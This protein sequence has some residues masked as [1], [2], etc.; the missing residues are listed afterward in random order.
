MSGR[1]FLFM[2]WWIWALAVLLTSLGESF[3][4]EG[5]RRRLLERPADGWRTVW[6]A[7]QLGALSP[8]SRGRI[9][10]QAREL[11]ARRVSPLGVMA[12][13]VSAQS[14]L[15]WLLL[16]I[17]ELDGPQP[18]LGLAVAVAV[19]LAVLAFGLAR[20][21]AELWDAA[22]GDAAREFSPA[23]ERGS[24]P[25][26]RGGPVWL[27]LPMSALGQVYS[28]WWPMLV[29]LAGVGFFLAL[30]QSSGYFSLQGTRGPLIQVGNV[31]AGLLVAYVTGAPLVGHALIAAGL[32]KADF[33]TYAGLSAFYMGTMVTPFVIP[34]YYD[35]LGVALA[36]RVLVWLVAAI[37]VGA[38][39][40]TAWWWGLDWFAGVLGVRDWF[41]A[42]TASTLR[43]NNVPWFHHWF[44]P[45]L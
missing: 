21:P 45:G 26:G 1:H 4:V 33:V 23:S 16:F 37:L 11:L 2:F 22:R 36:K 18:V 43:P 35:L 34:R 29:G 10:R 6:L 17:V 15:L 7:V 5:R 8:P 40:A 12:Y 31:G 41:E 30:G 25:I 38:L 19:A 9:F 20:T 27:R 28:L 39:A 13:V 3:W 32:W 44:A 14:L 42:F 24:G